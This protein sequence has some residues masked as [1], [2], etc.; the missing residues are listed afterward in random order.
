[1]KSQRERDRDGLA[2]AASKG[3]PRQ[4]QE[5]AHQFRKSF[6]SSAG[7]DKGGRKTPA[8]AKRVSREVGGTPAHDELDE[9]LSPA[10]KALLGKCGV[11]SNPGDSRRSV[12]AMM[13][14]RPSLQAAGTIEAFQSF[15]ELTSLTALVAELERHVKD[16][17]AGDL[18]I[19]EGLLVTQAL[20]LNTIFGALAR[21][22]NSSQPLSAFETYLRLA[23]KAQSQ[24]RT[25]LETLALV[26][27]PAP[28]AFVR[29]ANIGHQVQ[30]NNGES[31]AGKQPGAEIPPNKLLEQQDARLDQS[32]TR[33]P[34]APDSNLAPVGKLHGTE[35]ANGESKG[36]KKRL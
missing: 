20:A 2:K 19:A 17:S 14:V 4:R 29:Q 23:L 21:R 9:D 3:V 6:G 28:I 1:M 24:C 27:N 33:A 5:L 11:A 34:A 16:V 18:A 26:K 13:S 8:I 25:T 31:R 7:G 30:V 22:A 12:I 10:A 15:G 36:R 35:D 32:S